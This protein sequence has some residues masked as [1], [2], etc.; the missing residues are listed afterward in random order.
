MNIAHGLQL[1]YNASTVASTSYNST[2]TMDEDDVIID[3]NEQFA[4]GEETNDTD[5]IFSDY[6]TAQKSQ[7]ATWQRIV[8]MKSAA[9]EGYLSYFILSEREQEGLPVYAKNLFSVHSPIEKLSQNTDLFTG[10]VESRQQY[11]DHRQ[12]V[13]T[14]LQELSNLSPA[15]SQLASKLGEV[16]EL[17][18]MQLYGY[19][20]AALQD[21]ELTLC[22]EA[23]R[24]ADI[25]KKEK[26]IVYIREYVIENPSTREQV[27]EYIHFHM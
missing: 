16:K 26:A 1:V 2:Y 19:G 10:I 6:Q 11:L 9:H 22:L 15:G 25:L 12:D 14:K 24:I 13:I 27:Q 20:R 21:S 23:F 8:E 3:I 4:F 5:L 7:S 18:A 17:L